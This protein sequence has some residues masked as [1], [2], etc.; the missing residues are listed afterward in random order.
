ML[1]CSTLLTSCVFAV[2]VFRRLHTTKYREKVGKRCCV[3]SVS[4]LSLPIVNSPSFGYDSIR[5][6]R[7]EWFRLALKRMKLRNPPLQ[8]KFRVYAIITYEY[9]GFGSHETGFGWV[10]GTNWECCFI[11]GSLCAERAA[12]V[13]LRE[14]AVESTRIL[15]VYLVSDMDICI[16]PGVLCREYL[17]S[18]ASPDTP[19]HMAGKD[20]VNNKTLTLKELY[21]YYCLYTAVSADEAV[22]IGK[23]LSKG[24]AMIQA[25][26]ESLPTN[27][28]GPGSPLRKLY[29]EAV[30]ATSKDSCIALHPI[31]YAA[32]VY[33]SDG[34]IEVSWQRKALEYGNTLDAVSS[35]LRCMQAKRL[36][37][38]SPDTNVRA[39]FGLQVDQFGILHA[40]FAPA[41]AQLSELGF[42]DCLFYVHTTKQNDGIARVSYHKNKLCFED[43]LSSI[44]CVSVEALVPD[45]PNMTEIFG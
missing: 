9:R 17:L 6:S 18:L 44:H 8:S 34:T 15:E 10:S 25:V 7:K 37:I 33:F 19:I 26:F 29:A 30:A 11:G 21:P 12:A 42:A 38:V 32:G 43:K 45:A 16:T 3:E 2:A 39:M 14:L 41:R 4:N 40:P 20:L 27:E 36:Q 31:R 5:R 13:Q 1:R 35:L 24:G 22:H 23:E 28:W